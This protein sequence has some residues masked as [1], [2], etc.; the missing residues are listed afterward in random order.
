MKIQI[1]AFILTAT[2]L[3]ETY[4]EEYHFAKETFF[5][6]FISSINNTVY[7]NENGF[8]A[9][10]NRE[11]AV[12]F[13][14]D[15]IFKEHEIGSKNPELVG[16]DKLSLNS[17]NFSVYLPYVTYTDNLGKYRQVVF[18]N[19]ENAEKFIEMVKKIVSDYWSNSRDM[20]ISI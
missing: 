15:T 18:P 14:I 20:S 9:R 13:N 4:R 6:P 7:Q 8:C 16:T 3:E 12:K 17:D 1:D 10:I 11:D 19:V 5:A 2:L